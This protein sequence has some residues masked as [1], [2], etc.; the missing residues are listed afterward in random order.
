MTVAYAKPPHPRLV[1]T[2]GFPGHA[3]RYPA[4]AECGCTCVGYL[5]HEPTLCY[6]CYT[7]RARAEEARQPSLWGNA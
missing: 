1:C 5:R 3:A 7:E 2:S 6:W 4:C